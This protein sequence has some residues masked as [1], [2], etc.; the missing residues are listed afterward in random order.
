M[1]NFRNN[2]KLCYFLQQILFVLFFP[3]VISDSVKLFTA[4]LSA[5]VKH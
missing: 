1:D 4:S 5:Q 2:S 3:L